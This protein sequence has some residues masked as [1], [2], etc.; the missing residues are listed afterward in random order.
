LQNAIITSLFLI[1]NRET[2]PCCGRADGREREEST[3]PATRTLIQNSRMRHEPMKSPLDPPAPRP[4]PPK[5]AQNRRETQ[6]A[7]TKPPAGP[8]RHPDQGSRAA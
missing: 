2:P 3:I 4:K 5:T 8:W 1:V 6:Q 7:A